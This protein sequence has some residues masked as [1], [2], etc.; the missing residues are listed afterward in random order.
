MRGEWNGVSPEEI[1]FEALLPEGRQALED[2]RKHQL[3]F[4]M[5]G[6]EPTA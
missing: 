2:E 4:V 3:G 6:A 5:A 1:Q